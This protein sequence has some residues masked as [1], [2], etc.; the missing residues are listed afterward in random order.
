MGPTLTRDVREPLGTSLL[1]M[2]GKWSCF[3][4][5]GN[6][7][8]D[9]P[10]GDNSGDEVIGDNGGFAGGGKNPKN[11]FG[12]FGVVV[13]DGSGWSGPEMTGTDVDAFVVVVAFD[14]SEE[15]GVGDDDLK[16]W[17]YWMISEVCYIFGLVTKLFRSSFK[18]NWV[19][20]ARAFVWVESCMLAFW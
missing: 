7:G 13:R 4:R 18:S 11:R 3:W 12:R 9:S 17:Q 16:K 1:K 14:I 2:W 15:G 10:F 6:A 5:A 20:Y 19:P 8:E